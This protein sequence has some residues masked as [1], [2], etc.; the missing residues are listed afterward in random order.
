MTA[1]G[2]AS[3]IALHMFLLGSGFDRD[4][5]VPWAKPILAAEGRDRAG[6]LFAASRRYLDAV[7][8]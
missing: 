3:T 8:T 7:L 1:P 6:L 4:S 5:L 2:D